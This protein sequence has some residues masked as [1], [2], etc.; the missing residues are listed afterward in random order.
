MRL[1]SNLEDRLDLSVFSLSLVE[2]CMKTCVISFHIIYI[3]ETWICQQLFHIFLSL[4]QTH[5]V[6]LSFN[7]IIRKKSNAGNELE[8][9]HSNFGCCIFEV[10]LEEQCKVGRFVARLN[11][12]M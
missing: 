9:Q 6:L 5:K 1:F 4:E 10:F 7:G 8:L 12:N 2:L 11:P 3:N